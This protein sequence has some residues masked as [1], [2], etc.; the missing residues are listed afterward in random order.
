MSESR[1]NHPMPR[2]DSNDGSARLNLSPAGVALPSIS[3]GPFRLERLTDWLGATRES[4]DLALAACRERIAREDPA[5]HAW[6]QVTPQPA[7]GD[8]PLAGIPFGVK[9]II[10]AKGLA[11]EYG[12]PIYRGRVGSTD[13]AI[14]QTL[15][16]LGG[17]LLGMTRSTA[18]AYFTPTLTRNPRNPAHTPGGSSSGSAAAVAA[19]MVPVALGTQT[20]GSV[21]RPASFCGITGFKPSFGLLPMEGVFPFAPSLDTLGFFTATVAD[22]A[23]LWKT[24]GH[25]I[26]TREDFALAAP[27]SIPDVEPAMQVAFHNAI[28]RLRRAGLRIQPI[29]LT[30]MQASLETAVRIVMHYEGARIHAH[31]HREHPGQMAG[32]ADLVREGL[33]VPESACEEAGR[34]I[35]GWKL[36]AAEWFRTTPIILTPAALGPAPAGLAS[37]GNPRMNAPWTALGTPAISVPLPV[38]DRMPLG[39]QLTADRGQDARLLRAAL[40]VQEIFEATATPG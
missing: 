2:P 4:R 21:L 6:V 8:G 31:H 14:V 3:S 17:V 15:R 1:A 32:F 20:A 7:T 22:M 10:E 23:A 37:T 25:A 16:R 12:S 19:G 5:I 40:R 11:T 28:D 27:E 30:A 36:Q 29:D 34:A 33:Q 35:A 26:G 24:L 18:F 9:E 13:A 39:L 38:G